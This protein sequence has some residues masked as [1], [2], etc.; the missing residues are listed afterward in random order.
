MT[1]KLAVRSAI[2][3][4]FGYGTGQVLRF[5]SNLILTRLL[6]PEYF[7]L[8]SVVNTLRI[9]IELFSDIGILQSI[10]NNK[11]GDEPVFL[12]TAWTLQ[13]IRGV[14]L[15]LFLLIVTLPISTFYHDQRLLWLIPIAG[16]S[17]ILDGFCSTS[18]YTL[19]RRLQLGKLI[20][21]DLIVQVLTLA[22]LIIWSLLSP[23]LY[24]LA[25]G[26]IAGSIYKMVGSHWLIRG[27][28]NRFAW[29]RDAVVEILTFAKWMFVA[30]AVMFLND[31]A[32]RLILAKLLS[33]Q[34]LGVYT[35]AYALAGIPREVVKQLGY[36][37]IFPTIA[38]HIDLP[39]SSLRD[40][41]LRQRRIMLIGFAFLLAILVTL[42][43][44][45]ISTL[46]DQRYSEATWMMPILSC[47]VWFSVLFYTIS[48]ALMAIGKPMYAA[49]SNLAGFLVIGLGLPLAFFNF[50]TV[51]AIVLIALSD[52]PLYF[53]NLYGL[54]REKLLTIVQ[55]IQ[56]T[57]FF[58]GVLALFLF[59]RSYLG[60]GIPIHAIL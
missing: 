15:W 31:Q 54:G 57:A 5:G 37:V 60:F 58:V 52:M 11:R 55:D 2:W 56:C 25:F 30:S 45:V 34:L 28:S 19:H 18:L 8:M 40:K 1:K 13:T 10:V 21:F 35:I 39:R 53:V 29:D 22:T 46:Y 26:V 47:G 38:N 43:D 48:P 14:I 32:D 59:I 6:V 44:L 50:G 33:F 9:G 49:Q 42:G 12:N 16:M 41:I 51:G 36:K 27:Y 3:T 4:V 24:A 17:S 20:R 7:G 23:G